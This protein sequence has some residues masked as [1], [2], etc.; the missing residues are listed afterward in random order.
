MQIDVLIEPMAG[1]GYR[2]SGGAPF[3]F[4]AEGTTREEALRKFQEMVEGRFAG[5]AQLVRLDVKHGEPPWAKFAGTWPPNDPRIA[6]WEQAIEEYR[7]KVDEDP[8]AP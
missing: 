2:A 8:N 4:T 1:N 6:A 3:A 5:G 7:Q